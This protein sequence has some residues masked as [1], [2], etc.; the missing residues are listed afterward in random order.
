MSQSFLPIHPA[1]TLPQPGGIAQQATALDALLHWLPT[2]LVLVL[3]TTG[4]LLH[5]N[6]RAAETLRVERATATRWQTLADFPAHLAPLVQR[7]QR[8]PEAGDEIRQEVTLQFPNDSKPRVIGYS[9]RLQTLHGIG[10]AWALVFSDITRVLEEKAAGERLKDELFQTKKMAAMGNLITGVAHELN[11]PLIAIHMSA[12]LSCLSVER[13]LEEARTSP[14]AQSNPQAW[15][16]DVETGLGRTLAEMQRVLNATLQANTLVG[17]LLNYSRPTRLDLQL[18]DLFAYVQDRIDGWQATLLQV[19]HVRCVLVPPSRSILLKIDPLKMEQVLFHVLQNAIEAIDEQQT[20]MV[21]V[22]FQEQYHAE[23]PEQSQV[24]MLITDT[25]CGMR[26][27]QLERVFEPF[28]T[29]KGAKGTGLGLS[30]AYVA[31][32]QHGGH[33]TLTSQPGQGTTVSI[34][35][36]CP[37]MDPLPTHASSG[38]EA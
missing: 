30:Q 26:P 24:L 29:T 8:P 17:D 34:S 18:V 36:P 13:L 6:E 32:E 14:L 4:R 22:A 16:V 10:P 19:P 1:A 3:P 9:L 33:I 5:L 25:G 15:L 20:G 31:V 28:F 12:K 7:L 38:T 27:E 35:L 2:A 37:D 11:N 23:Q 21:S